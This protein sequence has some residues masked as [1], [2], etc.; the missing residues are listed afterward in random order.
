MPENLGNIDPAPWFTFPARLPDDLIRAARKNRV[1]R[2]GWAASFFHPY[3]DLS[4]LQDVVHGIQALGYTYVPLADQVP[5]TVTVDPQSVT[6]SLDQAITLNVM[7]VGTSPMTYRWRFNGADIAGATNTMLALNHAQLSDAGAYSVAV[8]N[9]LGSTLS[10]A[11]TVRV[12]APFA[13]GSVSRSGGDI[14]FSFA[15]QPG[16]LY[17][18]TYKLKLSDPQWLPLAIV[19][20]NGGI[21]RVTDPSP[22]EPVRFYRVLAQ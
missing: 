15:S 17:S 4:Y 8:S 16:V 5:P 22:A 20:G 12:I 9:A 2:D 18:I 7:A 10:G 6:T 13:I 3:L 11:A 21:L 14:A 19:T 1:V